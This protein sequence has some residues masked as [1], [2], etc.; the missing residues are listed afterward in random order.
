MKWVTFDQ[1][2]AYLQPHTDFLQAVQF[3]DGETRYLVGKFSLRDEDEQTV[4]IDDDGEP[5]TIIRFAQK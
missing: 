5:I 1:L 3:P 4:E 2:P